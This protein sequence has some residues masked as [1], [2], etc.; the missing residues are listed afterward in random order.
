MIN[1]PTHQVVITIS[2]HEGDPE[3]NLQVNWNPLLD[4]SEI[5]EQGFTP[6]SYLVAQH[7]LFATEAM[8]D[9]A[10]LLEIEEGDMSA[11]RSIN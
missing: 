8:I 7:L 4:D 11:G 5:L 6:A 2:S 1:K 10:Q 9:T 3:V